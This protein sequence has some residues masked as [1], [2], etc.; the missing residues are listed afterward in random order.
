MKLSLASFLSQMAHLM[1]FK[2]RITKKNVTIIIVASGRSYIIIVARGNYPKK[3]I[4]AL[5][6]KAV[7]RGK[8]P[9]KLIVAPELLGGEEYVCNVLELMECLVSS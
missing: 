5:S 3:L 9:K 4:V 2:H 1:S 6:Y 8:F 7:A